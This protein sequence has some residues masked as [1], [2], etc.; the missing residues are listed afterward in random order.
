MEFAV[1][2]IIRKKLLIRAKGEKTF[3]LQTYPT[4]R[5]LLMCLQLLGSFYVV[6]NEQRYDCDIM[7][8]DER[9][10]H[11]RKYYFFAQECKGNY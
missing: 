10:V 3:C 11:N 2:F 7:D 9:F 4:P 5:T 8:L 6:W 1:I